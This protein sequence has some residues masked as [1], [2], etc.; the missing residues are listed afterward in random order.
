MKLMQTLGSHST[1][2]QQSWRG[3]GGILDSPCLSVRPSIRVSVDDMV[4]GA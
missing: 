2:A 3:G 4:S 1:H